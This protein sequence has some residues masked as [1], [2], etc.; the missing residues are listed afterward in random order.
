MVDTLVETRAVLPPHHGE[1]LNEAMYRELL[2]KV[3]LWF[4]GFTDETL[5]TLSADLKTLVDAR[6]AVLDARPPVPWDAIAERG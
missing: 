1:L 2:H 4:D 3:G 5:L 6:R